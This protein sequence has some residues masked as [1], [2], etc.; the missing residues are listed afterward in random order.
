MFYALD[1]LGNNISIDDALPNNK[2]YC[3]LCK[4][5]LVQK[6]GRVKVH[7]FSH[8]FDN[9]CPFSHREMSSWHLIWQSCFDK[10]YC[11]K[12]CR[13][14]EVIHIA[15]VLINDTV[16]EFQHSPISYR[17]I[18]DR[19]VFHLDNG[20]KIVW[21]FDFRNKYNNTIFE[22]HQT[23]Y[24][25]YMC[26]KYGIENI[27]RRNLYH[28]SRPNKSINAIPFY[29]EQVYLFLQL[30]DDLIIYVDWNFKSSSGD[31][32]TF[33]YFTGEKYTKAMFMDKVNKIAA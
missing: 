22:K 28:W 9:T 6:K 17:D 25:D 2:Y 10:R 26:N 16:I 24:F 4:R 13:T 30:C 14:E 7:H 32:T 33:E 15:D 18:E 19:T 20:R 5:E 8:S 12:I 3:P 27:N 1:E 29:Y 21:L 31:L 11:E 23:Q